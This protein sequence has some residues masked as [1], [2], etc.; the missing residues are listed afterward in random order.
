MPD[1]QEFS[2]IKTLYERALQLRLNPELAKKEP[3]PEVK[4]EQAVS[5]E[6][7]KE[8]EEEEETEFNL[9]DQGDEIYG[10]LEIDEERMVRQV[11]IWCWQVDNCQVITIDLKNITRYNLGLTSV[12][13]FL[14]TD[15]SYLNNS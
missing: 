13:N 10:N 15:L 9:E 6:V 1:A 4:P 12:E 3:K 5:G 14:E 7:K 11:L 2:Q 8:E